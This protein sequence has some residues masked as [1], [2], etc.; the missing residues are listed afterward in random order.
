[1]EKEVKRRSLFVAE[2]QMRVTIELIQA[3]RDELKRKGL[4]NKEIIEIK[5][6]IF[7]IKESLDK[8]SNLLISSF[9]KE[10]LKKNLKEKNAR[11][12]HK[13]LEGSY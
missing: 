2:K 12:R 10:D 8:L 7:S 11:Q 9:V 4:L 1:L 6:D 5:K 3:Q 13:K